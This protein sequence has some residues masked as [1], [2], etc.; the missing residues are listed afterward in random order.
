LPTLSERREDIAPLAQHFLKTVAARNGKEM[1]GFAPDALE[2][3][4]T[5]PWPGNV[6]QLINVVEQVVALS[7]PGIVPA[8]LVQQAL[9]QE[10]QSFTSLEEARRGFERDYLVRI[11][12]ITA[13][14]V[15]R[16]AKLAQRNRTEFYKL[17]ERHALE[18][19]QFKSQG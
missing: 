3:M 19:K 9:R 14:N 6:R 11:L 12:R 1:R 5:A 17:L 15:T 16:A 10:S 7:P 4:L 8:S 2:L 13:G 18:P